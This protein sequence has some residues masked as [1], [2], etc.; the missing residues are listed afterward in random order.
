MN[1]F[2]LYI[3]ALLVFGVFLNSCTSETEELDES[4]FGYDYFPLSA[5]KSWVYQSDSIVYSSVGSVRDTFKSFIKEE[6]GEAFV[7]LTGQKVYKIDRFFKRNESDSWSRLNTWTSSVDKTNAIRT[8]ENIRFIKLVFPV[9][10]GLRFDGNIF[11]DQDLKIEV[12]GEMVEAYKNWEHRITSLDTPIKYK[13]Q[14]INALEVNLVDETSIIDRRKVI[15]YYA[16]EIGLV[17][18][19][20][21]ILDSDGSKPNDPWET[22]AK[23]GFIHRLTLIDHK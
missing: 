12:G 14:D 19:E 13:G 10:E 4:T 2:N 21:I 23:K 3:F 6:V 7:D 1:R 15:E 22:K 8:E 11:V 16:K 18:K 20:M 5:G 9:K 17:F